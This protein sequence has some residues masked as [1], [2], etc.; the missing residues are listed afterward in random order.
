MLLFERACGEVETLRV[1]S[2]WVYP[3]LVQVTGIWDACS[4]SNV[5]FG[6][7]FYE[8]SG[9]LSKGVRCEAVG[10]CRGTRFGGEDVVP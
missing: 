8:Q 9:Y 10:V 5:S 3:G 2:N 1:G 7:H 4:G 6:L